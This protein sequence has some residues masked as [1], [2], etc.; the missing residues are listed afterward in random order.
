M[1]GR[2]QLCIK[3]ELF[4]NEVEIVD[5]GILNEFFNGVVELV[6]NFFFLIAVLKTKQPKIELFHPCIDK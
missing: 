6:W 5:K 4:N 3:A 2:R 1:N